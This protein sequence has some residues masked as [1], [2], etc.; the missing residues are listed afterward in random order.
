M[1]QI[2]LNAFLIGSCLQLN[3]QKKIDISLPNVP[4]DFFEN[5]NKV[6]LDRTENNEI[7]SQSTLKQRFSETNWI[8]NKKGLNDLDLSIVYDKF[9]KLK[10]LEFKIYNSK[11]ELVKTYKE[12][13]FTDSSLADGFS[14]LTDNRIK[15]LNPSYFDYPFYTKFD[16]EIDEENTISI[17]SFMPLQ[18]SDDRV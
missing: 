2:L 4:K 13:D 17:P 15:N 16:Y 6:I 12:K 3:A 10:N 8:L 1:K 14:V 9:S 18:S 5:T 7:L 11:G